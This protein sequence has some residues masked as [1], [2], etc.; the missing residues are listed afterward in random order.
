MIKGTVEESSY[1]EIVMIIIKVVYVV[2]NGGDLPS[3]RQRYLLDL[4]GMQE[5]AT[6]GILSSFQAPP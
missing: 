6:R 5:P 1:C 4:F 2:V 3:R